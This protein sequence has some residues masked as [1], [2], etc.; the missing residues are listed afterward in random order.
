MM[1]RP[2]KKRIDSERAKLSRLGIQFSASFNVPHIRSE[3]NV[4]LQISM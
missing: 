2:A 1:W 3:F 4:N